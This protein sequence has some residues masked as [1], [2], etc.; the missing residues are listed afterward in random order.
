MDYLWI[1]YNIVDSFPQAVVDNICIVD[2]IHIVIVRVSFNVSRVKVRVYSKV[3]SSGEAQKLW[4][5]YY[6]YCISKIIVI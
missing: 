4:L 1:I 2:S 5:Y 3:T 6:I